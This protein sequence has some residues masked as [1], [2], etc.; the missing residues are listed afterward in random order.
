[1]FTYAVYILSNYARSVFYIG[2]TSDLMGRMLQYKSGE[3]GA[4]RQS[5]KATT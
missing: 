3:G 5:I 4:L 2:V 1:M